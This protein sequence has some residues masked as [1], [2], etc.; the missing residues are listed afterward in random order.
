M[1]TIKQASTLTKLSIDTIRYYEKAGLLPKIKRLPN[2][3]RV[4]SQCDI[5]RLQLIVCMKKASLSLEEVKLY[6]DIAETSKMTS[7]M[8]AGML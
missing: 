5:Q 2:G 7:E 3:H 8:K 6:L 4:F 1:Y